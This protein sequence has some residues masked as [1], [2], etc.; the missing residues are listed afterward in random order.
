MINLSDVIKYL[1]YEEAIKRYIDN[2]EKEIRVERMKLTE[3]KEEKRQ[4][5]IGEYL[6][7]F[8]Q[9]QKEIC[10]IKEIKRQHELNCL[11]NYR[12]L[13]LDEE[14]EYSYYCLLC[15][16]KGKI[17]S[18]YYQDILSDILLDIRKYQD[19]NIEELIREIKMI[20]RKL[21]KKDPLMNLMQVNELIIEELDLKKKVIENENQENTHAYLRRHP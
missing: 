3:V 18:L 8:C 21:Y 6:Q 19:K 5:K 16:S 11:H 9:K 7:M 13:Y 17:V 1:D 4:E 10:N 2:Y 12:L 20:L 14:N 15:G